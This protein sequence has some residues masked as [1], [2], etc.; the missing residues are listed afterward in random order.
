MKTNSSNLYYCKL[1]TQKLCI[2]TYI[3]RRISFTNMKNWWLE[4]DS[5]QS[6]CNLF[7]IGVNNYNYVL[8]T[9]KYLNNMVITRKCYWHVINKYENEN[10]CE[11]VIKTKKVFF[12]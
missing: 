10:E 7:P 8:F 5:R 9:C 4:F 3:L 11:N 1:H 2:R 12:M 6:Q